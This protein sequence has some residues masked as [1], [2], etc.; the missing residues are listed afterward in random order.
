MTAVNTVDEAVELLTGIPAGERDHE[1]NYPPETINGR[2]EATL[3]AF[4]KN[5][6]A[7]DKEGK[8]ND[9]NHE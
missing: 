6:Q 8:E 5:L 7:F 9:K 4:A 3:Q 2:V 1:G